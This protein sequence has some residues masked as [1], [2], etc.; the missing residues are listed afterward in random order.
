M[1][2]GHHRMD[3]VAVVDQAIAYRASVCSASGV[4]RTTFARQL[5]REVSQ[6]AR[7]VAQQMD[8]VPGCPNHAPDL[9]MQALCP[10]SER[11]HGGR[12]GGLAAWYP[13]RYRSRTSTSTQTTRLPPRGAIG[14][15]GPHKAHHVTLAAADEGTHRACAGC[16]TRGFETR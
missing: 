11:L 5:R 16:N 3:F 7:D 1:I 13:L 10:V 8:R 15:D 9:G 12:I 4:A 14:P 2:T 6:N